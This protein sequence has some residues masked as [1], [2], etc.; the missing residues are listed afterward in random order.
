MSKKYQP[1]DSFKPFFV[2]RRRPGRLEDIGLLNFK[3]W[4]DY[5]DIDLTRV[6][7][8][9]GKNSSGK[10]SFIQSLL[11]LSEHESDLKY[12]FPALNINS[13]AG[14]EFLTETYDLGN[15]NQVVN[16]ENKKKPIV[17]YIAK[18][19]AG[20]IV[21][22]RLSYVDGAGT[23]ATL[24]EFSISFSG[25]KL[26]A[27]EMGSRGRNRKEREKKIPD[28]EAILLDGMITAKAL[29]LNK[30]ADLYPEYE[31]D[32]R[33]M[34]KYFSLDCSGLSLQNSLQERSDEHFDVPSSEFYKDIIFRQDDNQRVSGFD[35]SGEEYVSSE[36]HFHGR[37]RRDGEEENQK[38]YKYDGNLYLIESLIKDLFYSISTEIV[39][40]PP[41]RG[42]PARLST[43]ITLKD[44]D[45]SVSYVY[46]KYKEVKQNRRKKRF[47]GR[48]N[49]INRN[50]VK[51][52]DD[53]LK[54]L[55]T[56]YKLDTKSTEAV[57]ATLT[58]LILTDSTGKELTFLDVGRGI[59]QLI[60]IIVASHAEKNKT[61][62]V[63]QP[64]VHIHPKLQADIADIFIDENQWIIETHSENIL[65]RIQKNI[66][67]G[68]LSPEDARCFYIDKLD[69][70]KERIL[71]DSSEDSAEIIKKGTVMVTTIGFN[72]DGSLDKEFPEGFFDVGL[73]EMLS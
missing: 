12:Q 55:G 33:L 49:E 68:K 65:F 63:E 37:F 5:E 54:R 22:L 71:E 28:K 57:G 18:S 42:L 16:S 39:H 2:P 8:I 46:S 1:S 3:G 69:E 36:R 60:P 27:R 34:L 38:K 25:V 21:S 40:I 51:Q 7:L 61:I 19:I 50:L 48:G 35:R 70:D 44:G 53:T 47:S 6:N 59:S 11:A 73:K 17:Y 13:D 58:N 32:E 43:E 20:G 30:I 56:D 9:F 4:R 41:H 14:L 62:I 67:E 24:E 45:P 10:S 26:F 23:R 64:E 66:R 72:E 15:F 52:V 29:N 31:Q